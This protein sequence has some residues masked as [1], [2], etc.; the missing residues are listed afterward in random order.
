MFIQFK[1]SFLLLSMG[2]KTNANKKVLLR[3]R[4]RC[5]VCGVVSP[6][7]LGGG[8]DGERVPQS[9]LQLGWGGGGQMEGWGQGGREGGEGYMCPVQGYPLSSLVN[10]LKTLPSLVLRTRAVVIQTITVIRSIRIELTANQEKFEAIYGLGNSSDW[11][12]FTYNARNVANVA[13]S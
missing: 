4:K 9:G 12:C 8:G 3:D 5:T 2:F 11:P 10:K 7:V 1:Y 6:P 13:Q